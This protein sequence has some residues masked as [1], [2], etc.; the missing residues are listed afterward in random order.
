MNPGVC[1]ELSLKQL[2]RERNLDGLPLKQPLLQLENS[3]RTV[4]YSNSGTNL[5]MSSPQLS[6]FL[7]ELPSR[8]RLLGIVRGLARNQ[9]GKVSSL[10]DLRMCVASLVADGKQFLQ[11]KKE[12]DASEWLFILKEAIEKELPPGTERPVCQHVEDWH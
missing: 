5:L 10:T 8:Q 11:L 2:E 6:H 9:P 7:A 3:S 12:H 4:C 1:N